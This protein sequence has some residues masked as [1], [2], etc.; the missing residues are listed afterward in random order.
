M[1]LETR[2]ALGPLDSVAWSMQSTL[3]LMETIDQR[4]TKK[5]ITCHF[6]MAPCLRFPDGKRL[7][8]TFSEMPHIWRHKA[9][10]QL[11]QI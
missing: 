7:L 5:Y 1:T 4:I 8:F 2:A 3:I 10:L 11:A 6:Q 9:M